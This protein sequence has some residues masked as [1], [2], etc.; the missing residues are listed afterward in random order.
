VAQAQKALVDID[1]RPHAA[2]RAYGSSHERD[3]LIKASTAAK[4]AIEINAR[5]TGLDWVC[6]SLGLTA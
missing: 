5:S 3:L 1:R 2:V 6:K 4:A